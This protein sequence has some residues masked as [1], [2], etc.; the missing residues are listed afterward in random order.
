MSDDST[1]SSIKTVLGST[2]RDQHWH[3]TDEVDITTVLVPYLAHNGGPTQTHA[4][5][6]GSVAVDWIP[7]VDCVDADGAPL[8]TDQRGEPR[9]SMCDVG[10]FEVPP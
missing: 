2:R 10:A 9:D 3:L 5:L 6:P 7:E 1:Y 4:L 8:A